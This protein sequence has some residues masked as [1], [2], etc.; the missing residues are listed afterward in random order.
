MSTNINSLSILTHQKHKIAMAFRKFLLDNP[1]RS[2]GDEGYTCFSDHMQKS[3]WSYR[4]IGVD[5]S[6]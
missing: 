5:A 1:L 6:I 3:I 4:Q 2:S